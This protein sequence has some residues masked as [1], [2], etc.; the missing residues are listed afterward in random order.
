MDVWCFQEVT[1]FSRF[2]P[3]DC[4]M[5]FNV[6]VQESPPVPDLYPSLVDALGDCSPYLSPPYSDSSHNLA[7]FVRKSLP[8]TFS[9]HPLM[10]DIEV[11][12][13][14]PG[15]K[16]H[17]GSGLLSAS[18]LD[19]GHYNVFTTHGIW[20]GPMKEDTPERLA[21]SSRIMDIMDA[22]D[23]PKILTGDLNLHPATESIRMLSGRMTDWVSESGVKSTRSASFYR[24]V[25]SPMSDYADF[26]FT[27]PGIIVDSFETL[28]LEVSDHLP[29]EIRFH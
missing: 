18:I 5:D 29:L 27:S 4:I 7:M 6:S 16:Y 21:Q 24:K 15:C 17:T 3:S 11:P 13:R 20:Q 12:L 14:G 8:V 23:G 28:P 22:Y 19:H 26:V 2:A 9:Y 1:Y 10:Q 25:P